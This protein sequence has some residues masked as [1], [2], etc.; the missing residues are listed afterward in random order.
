MRRAN[1]VTQSRLTGPRD[2]HSPAG[3][4]RAHLLDARQQAKFRDR[5]QA[6]RWR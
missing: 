6:A 5:G 2:R 3:D 4:E 1:G